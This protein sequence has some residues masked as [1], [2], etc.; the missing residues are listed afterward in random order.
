MIEAIEKK[1]LLIPEN[2]QRKERSPEHVVELAT[3]I[4]RSGLIHPITIRRDAGGRPVLVAGECRSEA[5]EWLWNLGGQ[6]RCAGIEFPEGILPCIDLKNL[7]P[8]DAFEIELEENIRRQDLSWQDRATAT[9]QLF[10]LRKLQAQKRGEPQP[11][12]KDIA[13]ELKGEDVTGG[14]QDDVRKEIIISK[15]LGDK[16]VSNAK[17]VKEAFKIIKRKED[18]QR[19]A[20][21]GRSVG[22]TFSSADHKLFKGDCLTI[23][24]ALPDTSFDVILTDPP[25]G[26]DAQDYN[27]SGGK[28]HGGHF[29]DDTPLTFR[30]LMFEFIPETF[31]V[32]KPQAHLYMFCD[33]EHFHFLRDT[34]EKAGW[35]PFRT[36]FIAVNPTAMRAPW[37]DQ[38]PQRKWQMILYA[39][40]GDKHVNQLRPDVL[41]Y[42]SDDN[43]NHH[44]QKP[45]ALYQ[46]LL[47][48]SC[49]PGDSVIDPFCGTGTIFIAAHELKVRATGIE[50]DESAYGIA[51]KRLE[52][53]K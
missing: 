5:I 45:V 20:D 44:A 29:Y 6:V 25:Y 4:E 7:D 50:L 38:G 21:L 41:V 9:S 49:N 33:I 13:K 39:V 30:T 22:A 42:P 36:P 8:I 18:L 12:V 14:L 31:R 35:N 26:I 1:L 19:S 52:G 43:L 16:D 34:V 27:D 53:L 15:Y 48:R 51:V 32:T 11:T 3:S 24:K 17:S 2:R 40:K 47:A 46:D 37:P 10:E 23:L 28:T